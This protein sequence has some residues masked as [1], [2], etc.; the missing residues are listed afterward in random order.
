MGATGH[1]AALVQIDPSYSL[2]GA[3]VNTYINTRFHVKC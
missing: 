1:I 3:N 2:S